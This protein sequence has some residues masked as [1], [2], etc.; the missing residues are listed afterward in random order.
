MSGNKYDSFLKL[1]IVAP[2]SNKLTSLSKVSFIAACT[3]II[4]VIEIENMAKQTWFHFKAKHTKTL[5]DFFGL[6]LQG[7]A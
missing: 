2:C 4:A 1:E 6:S 7:S 3:E 5:C